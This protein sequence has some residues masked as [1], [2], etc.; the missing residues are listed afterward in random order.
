MG[1]APAAEQEQRDDG[2]DDRANT[3]GKARTV[4]VVVVASGAVPVSV[5]GV[6]DRRG[7]GVAV[8]G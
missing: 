6:A 1:P 8:A 4:R 5:A 3:G 2:H 7:G